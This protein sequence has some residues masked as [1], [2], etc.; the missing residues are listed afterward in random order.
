[1][2]TTDTADAAPWQQTPDTTDVEE[3]L[4]QLEILLVS[5]VSSGPTIWRW[6]VEILDRTVYKIVSEWSRGMDMDR[7][8]CGSP[9]LGL[10]QLPLVHVYI[11]TFFISA[12]AK[13]WH[14]GFVRLPPC[15]SGTAL[16]AETYLEETEFHKCC[17]YVEVRRQWTV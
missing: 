4:R 3:Q 12:T 14:Y 16:I 2:S 13:P 6:K 17:E 1:L 11:S 10:A 15:F 7:N 5:Q 9:G 8:F